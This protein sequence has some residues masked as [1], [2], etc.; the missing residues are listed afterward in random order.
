MLSGNDAD[1]IIPRLWLGNYKSSQNINFIKK[2]NISLIINCTKNIPSI[3]TRGVD[4]YR[5]PVEDNLEPVEIDRMT[6][7][8]REILPIIHKAYMM[9]R[10]ILVHC[11]AGM[12]RSAIIVL[13]YLYEYHIHDVKKILRLMK[14]RRPI[15]FTPQMNFSTSFI[16]NYDHK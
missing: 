8:I 1:E 15:V 13:S 11:V 10:S 4:V 5:V 16:T 2:N 3:N 9:G 12:Q 14:K 7:C 6:I